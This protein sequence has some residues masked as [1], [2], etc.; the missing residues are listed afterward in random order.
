MINVELSPFFKE[1]IWYFLL[2]IYQS[3]S[4]FQGDGVNVL[5]FL[6]FQ[7]FLPNNENKIQ[8]YNLN[9]W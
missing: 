9:F 6:F 8:K 1:K 3:V 4:L 7:K 2:K 5:L